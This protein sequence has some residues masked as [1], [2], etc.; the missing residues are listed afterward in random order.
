MI[1]LLRQVG[2]V[3]HKALKYAMD[4]TQPGAS[5][6]EICEKVEAYIRA[7]DAKPAF[8]ANISI[9]EVAAH[10]TAKRG[11]QL[12]VPKSGVV[13]IDVGAQKEG[14]IVDAAVTLVFGQ[15]YASL[16]KAARD[17]LEAALNTA[18]PGVRA[19]QIGEAVEKV[20][21]S[22][23][24]NPVYNLTGHKI[25]RYLLHAGHVIPNYPDKSAS[26]TLSHGDVYAVE[27]FVTN[28]EGYV[29]DGREVTIYRLQRLRH[30]T[31]QPLIDII[32]AE[33]GPLPFTPRWFPQISDDVLNQALKNGVVHGY[34][35][36]VERS[37][38]FVAQ[39]EDTI[40]VAENDVIPL[41]RTLE[42]V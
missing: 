10:Y 26:Q 6:L 34:E 28:G 17:A 39:F 32:T 18:R 37:R 30:K 5:V 11:D 9:N 31:M 1:R 13:K 3:V 25:E 20:A 21:K 16:A 4:I 23:G 40:Y 35:V 27:P 24:F 41:A 22:Y 12:V 36:L 14:Y 38:G 33:V 42:L 2:D 7:N 29:V 19:W 8:P 15:P